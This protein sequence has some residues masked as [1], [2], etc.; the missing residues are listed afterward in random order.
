MC[1]PDPAAIALIVNPASGR[2]RA[3]AIAARLAQRLADAGGAVRTIEVGP[4]RRADLEAELAGAARAV[5]VGG[6]GTVH[7]ALPALRATGAAVYHVPTGTENLFAREFAMTRHGALGPAGGGRMVDLGACRWSGAAG[8][9]EPVETLFAIMASLG[10]D[11]AVIHR[12]GARR[13][14]PIRRASYLGPILAEAL[15]PC[16]PE[17]SVECD[18]E[19]I[20]QRQ[21]GLLIIANSRHY[22]AR[23]NPARDA[24]VDDGLLD[25]VFF[26]ARSA[27][28]LARW[29]LLGRLGR[30]MRCRAVICRRGRQFTVTA[31]T[32][33]PL[34]IDGEGAD[35]PGSAGPG[36]LEV[37]AVPA[38]LR[39]AES[40]QR[41][42]KSEQ[43]AEGAKHK[44]ATH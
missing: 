30:H 23:M 38:A 37:R 20:L 32:P 17:L 12:L 29:A 13:R 40:E 7:R 8:A 6:D 27:F 10:F 15:R 18:G 28:G 44:A 43:K 39:V 34:Q 11:A 26:P 2:G 9:A 24:I 31:H 14:G 42:A 19:P 16:C 1:A 36:A 4:Q 35:W 5:I 25:L 22:A 41:T 21:R 33:A 3:G